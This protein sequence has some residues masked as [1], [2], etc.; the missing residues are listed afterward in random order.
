MKVA[1]VGGGKL[2][3][4]ITKALIGAGNEITV[5]DTNA[6]VI[7]RI[8]DT[9]DVMAIQK[10]AR[11][12]D[13]LKGIGI[14]SYDA[15]ICAT[16]DDEKNIFVASMAKSMGCKYA[17]AR[18]RDP[19]HISQTDEIRNNFSIDYLA[20]SDFACA[21][22]IYKYLT[23][24]K[25]VFGKRFIINKTEIFEIDVH[26][27]P[28]IVGKKLKETSDIFANL[29]LVAISRSGRIV[30][31]NGSTELSAD[32]HLF[33][34]GEQKNIVEF[35]KKLISSA[36]ETRVKNVMIGGGGKMS[37]FLAQML[38]R[39]GIG[40]K[41]I[42]YDPARCEYLSEKLE[43]ALILKGNAADKRIMLE[44]GIKNCDAYVAATSSDEQN[45]LIAW[46][47]QSHGVKDCIAKMSSTYYDSVTKRID[48]LMII[49][50][51]DMCSSDV[52]RRITND[53]NITFRSMLQGQAELIEI[54]AEEGMP[55]TSSSLA[56]LDIPEGV[57]IVS[58][59][60][61]KEIIM[62]T[63]KTQIMPGD[64]VILMSLLTAVG[65][66]ESLLTTAK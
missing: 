33:I 14:S 4:N 36:S 64:K 48:N 54:A 34:S 58:V 2:G 6:A 19:E 18:V 65:E 27:I 20:N 25:N 15:V 39:A 24:R 62:P 59:A 5:I 61:D 43:K 12:I 42:E 38:E 8:N 11:N 30:I 57:I 56:E 32:D 10:D 35:R 52:L 50:P 23:D 41:I 1:I 40:V 31:P 63:G 44:E 13:T 53:V 22:E 66:R 26:Q 45:L 46:E 17:V 16:S 47:A 49:N 51:V 60:R 29:L 7:S 55:L 37:F 21:K 28:N 3:S 9:F